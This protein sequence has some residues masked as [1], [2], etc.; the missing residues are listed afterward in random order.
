VATE[1]P[2]EPP[3]LLR[4]LA[5]HANRDAGA[6][7]EEVRLRGELAELADHYANLSGR[8]RLALL[9]EARR[10]RYRRSFS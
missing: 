5:V 6:Q 3:G 1:A 8:D 4:G 9:D 2:P 7:G 10:R